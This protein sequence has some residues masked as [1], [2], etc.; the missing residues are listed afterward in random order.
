MLFFQLFPHYAH[1]S[2]F[3]L[4]VSTPTMFTWLAQVARTNR[5]SMVS[6]STQST[7]TWALITVFMSPTVDQKKDRDQ[8]SEN[9]WSTFLQQVLMETEYLWS[10]CV[11][12]EL[13]HCC[14]QDNFLREN[15]F[16]RFI[17][18]DHGTLTQ[19]CGVGLSWVWRFK[20][21][22]M[23]VFMNLPFFV[24]LIL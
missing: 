9:H 18:L 14:L 21:N 19:L 12:L 22:Q 6:T 16:R 20:A 15:N 17:R 10:R 2:V 8:L 4:P 5:A 7:R 24:R 23:S 1:C 11:R 3:L 13:Q